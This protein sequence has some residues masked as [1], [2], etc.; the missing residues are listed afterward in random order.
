METESKMIKHLDQFQIINIRLHTVSQPEHT[1]KIIKR[2]NDINDPDEHQEGDKPINPF[3]LL[4]FLKW[5]EAVKPKICPSFGMT[6]NGYLIAMFGNKEKRI[7]IEF[8]VDNSLLQLKCYVSHI[9]VYK[10]RTANIYKYR[11]LQFT[12]FTSRKNPLLKVLLDGEE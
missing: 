11:D 9:D 12:E 8:S 7:S 2:L 10:Q 1:D 5:I 3:S 6:Y 4:L